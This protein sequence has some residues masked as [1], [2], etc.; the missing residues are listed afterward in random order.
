MC[1]SDGQWD[2]VKKTQASITDGP[3]ASSSVFS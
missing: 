2:S 3:V 1:L